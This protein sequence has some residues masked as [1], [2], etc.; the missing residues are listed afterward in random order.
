MTRYVWRDGCFRDPRTNEPMPMPER[1]GVCAPMVQSD[2]AEYR[3]P[4]DGTLIGSRSARRYDLQKNNCIEAD[5]PKKRRGY[6]NPNFA[7][8][9]GLP[10]NEEARDTMGRQP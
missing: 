1:D 8:K 2:I 10:L 7:L 4:I 3:S 5:P 9:R 6:R